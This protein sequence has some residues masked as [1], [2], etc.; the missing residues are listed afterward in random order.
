VVA[1]PNESHFDLTKACLLAGRD[2]VVDKLSPRPCEAQTLVELAAQQ[3]RLLT[4]Y[5][6]AAG[7][8]SFA[9]SKLVDAGAL[10]DIVEYESRFDRFRLEAKENA[11]RERADQPAPESSGIWSAPHRPGARIVWRAADHHCHYVPPTHNL[12]VDDASTSA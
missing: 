3:K 9:P 5:Q 11:W 2:V 12:V 6:T 4:V 10:G 7:T 1:T 8:E